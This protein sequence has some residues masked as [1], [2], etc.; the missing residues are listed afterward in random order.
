MVTLNLSN[1]SKQTVTRAA[2]A[3][4]SRPPWRLAK[5]YRTITITS[6]SMSSHMSR[7]IWMWQGS[8][9]IKWTHRWFK[10]HRTHSLSWIRT[11]TLG[12]TNWRQRTLNLAISK[13]SRRLLLKIL[14]QMYKISHNSSFRQSVVF[15]NRMLSISSSRNKKICSKQAPASIYTPYNKCHNHV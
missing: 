2:S 7:L 4:S 11:R 10:Y 9:M 3:N 14:G 13:I 6:H 5:P 15:K 8:H 12:R 1:P